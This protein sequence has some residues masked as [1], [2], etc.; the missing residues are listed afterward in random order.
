MLGVNDPEFTAELEE[1]E[2]MISSM[3]DPVAAFLTSE[4]FTSVAPEEQEVLTI[5]YM[6]PCM[7]G[8]Y[9]NVTMHAQPIHQVYYEM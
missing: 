2:A 3:G 9:Y 6:R 7:L 8:T 5:I 1:L 4:E